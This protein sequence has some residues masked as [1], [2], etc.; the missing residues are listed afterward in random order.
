[1][2]I[3]QGFISNSSSSSFTCGVCGAE[4]S[5]MNMCLEDA[6]MCECADGGHIICESHALTGY[7]DADAWFKTDKGKEE[8][9]VYMKENNC[10]EDEAIEALWDEEGGCRFSSK[11]CPICQFEEVVDSDV[12]AYMM[13]KNNTSYKELKDQLKKEFKNYDELCDFITEK[14]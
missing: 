3:R 7:K 8:V 1:M 12:V 5:G 13:K 14:E 11:F 4:E 6:E 10:D 2:K 9:A